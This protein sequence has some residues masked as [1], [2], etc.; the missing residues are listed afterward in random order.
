MKKTIIIITALALVL[1]TLGV[2]M[3]HIPSTEAAAATPRAYTV[4]V[5]DQT[6]GEEISLRHAWEAH[7]ES[8]STTPWETMPTKG[9][10]F[11][12]NVSATTPTV[13]MLKTTSVS[14]LTGMNISGMN[15]SGVWGGSAIILTMQNGTAI[16]LNP[17]SPQSG[18]TIQEK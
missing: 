13:A 18:L 10:G 6:R 7:G 8:G 11:S 9:D 2:C 17:T 12:L 4:I 5:L 1:T 14:G 16:T 15:V 3:L